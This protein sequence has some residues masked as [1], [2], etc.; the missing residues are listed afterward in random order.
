MKLA[1]LVPAASVLGAVAVSVFSPG[2]DY[3]E[4][5]P[6]TSDLQPNS[7]EASA[8]ATDLQPAALLAPEDVSSTLPTRRTDAPLPADGPVPVRIR[9]QAIDLDIEI[10]PVGVDGE[11]LFDVPSAEQAGWYQHGPRPGEQGSSVLAAHVDYNGQTGAFFELAALKPGD[12]IAI[13]YAD[14]ST[15]TFRV[16]DQVLYEKTSLPA[17]ELFRR[18]GDAVLQLATC[19]GSFDAEERSY[20][21]NRVVTAVPT[22]S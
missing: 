2:I 6:G 5:P 10:I 22:S 17:D 19:G 9:V 11:G 7:I 3:E 16:I 13:D 14:G 15:S 20:R 18:K 12:Q 21:G 8:R 1:W 4:A